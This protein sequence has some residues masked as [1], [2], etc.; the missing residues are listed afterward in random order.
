MPL[1]PD[2]LPDDVIAALRQGNKIEAIKLLRAKSG[3]D[4]KGAKDAIDAVEAQYLPKKTLAPGEVPRSK[5]VWWIV[6]F[7][8]VAMAAWFWLRR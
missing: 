6:A 4:L 1:E 2:P 7:A 3:L 5:G 8:A